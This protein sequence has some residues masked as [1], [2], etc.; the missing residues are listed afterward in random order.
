MSEGNLERVRRVCRDW[1]QGNFSTGL[2]LFDPEIHF[3]SFMPDSAETVVAEGPEGITDFMREFLASW[4]N[5][6]FIGDEFREAGDKVF[7]GGRQ[8][9]SG[10]QS[11]VDVEHE[12]YCV[13]T[14]RGAAAIGLKFTPDRE[15]AL[16]A[17]GLSGRG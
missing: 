16:Q 2:E 7:V 9:A 11:G 4:R 1:E 10:R 14:F 15:E 17:S 5:Y 12:M 8:A 3:E 13:W 6:R